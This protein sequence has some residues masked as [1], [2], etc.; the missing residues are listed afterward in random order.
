MMMLFKMLLSIVPGLPRQHR[1]HKVSPAAFLAVMASNRPPS[2]EVDRY[3]TPDGK[4]RWRIAFTLTPTIDG[5]VDHY[6][7]SFSEM[8]VPGTFRR[9]IDQ[10][11]ADMDR[12]GAKEEGPFDRLSATLS[13][14]ESAY[15]N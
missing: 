5:M 1:Y 2:I 9:F 3:R 15:G 4:V 11:K 6:A 14:P 13:L 12:T 7:I 10:A 8:F